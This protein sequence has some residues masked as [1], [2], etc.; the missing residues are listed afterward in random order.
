MATLQEI[1]E[2]IQPQHPVVGRVIGALIKA[3]WAAL[4]EDAGTAN[5]V[6]RLALANK[7]IVSPDAYVAK[8]W[9]LFL[10]NATVQASIDDLTQL[11]DSDILYVVQT[12]QFNTLANMEA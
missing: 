5:H 7:V 8:M 4:L 12:E 9:R 6:N 10:S 11:S 3:A 2:I 1:Y